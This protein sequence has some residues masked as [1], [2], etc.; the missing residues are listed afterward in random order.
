MPWWIWLVLAL[1]MVA[2]IVVG[3]VY[4][5]RRALAALDTVRPTMDRFDEAMDRLAQDG[6]SAQPQT[7]LFV[8]PLDVAVE[9]YSQTHAR[10]IERSDERRRRRHA[11][12]ARWARFGEDLPD[13]NHTAAV[14]GQADRNR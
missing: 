1:F 10:V 5:F 12:W 13:G 14:P 7:P 4:A 2:S 8:R 6:D 11:T 3:A 9:R